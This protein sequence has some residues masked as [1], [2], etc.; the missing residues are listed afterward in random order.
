MLYVDSE[1]TGIVAVFTVNQNNTIKT[2]FE[3]GLTRNLY[4]EG[5]DKKAIRKYILLFCSVRRQLNLICNYG[6][7]HSFFAISDI[8]YTL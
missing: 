1:M 5:K 8:N 4:I 7:W 6:T 3:K 2:N